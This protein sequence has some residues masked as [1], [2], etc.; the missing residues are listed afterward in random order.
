MRKWL[1]ILSITMLIGVLAACG[2]SEDKEAEE[3]PAGEV[4]ELEEV[5]FSDDELA[6][7]DDVVLKIDGKEI[8]GEEYNRLYR[9][10]KII[11]S[12]NQQLG[13]LEE[14]KQ[15]TLD[16]IIFETILTQDA[17][18]KGIEVTDEEF[19]EEFSF[20]KEEN[21]EGLENLLEQFQMTEDDFK[22]ELRYNILSQKYIESEFSDVEITDEEVESVYNELKE[23][24]SEKLPPLK[25]IH[26]NLKAQ[27]KEQE[28]NERVTEHIDELIKDASIE[29][30]I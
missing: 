23:E 16:L 12:A 1:T 21:S 19:D 24:D 22:E 18:D 27:L 25:D 30:N 4:E 6:P 15:D 11:K 5:E 28:I 2:S 20:I 3:K 10:S 29:Q 17:A 13:D 26:E 7:E 14:V 9:N 8:K